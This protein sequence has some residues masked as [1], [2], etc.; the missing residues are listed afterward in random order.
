V[1]QA[2]PVA[3]RRSPAA[4]GT[5]GLWTFLFID[6]VIFL[7]MFVAYMGERIRQTDLY[8]ASQLRLDEFVGLVNTLI[9]VTSSWMVVEAIRGARREDGEHVRRFLGLAWLLGLAFS[10]VKLGEYRLKIKAGWTP[11]TNSFFSFYF[12]ITSVHLL[13][14]LAGMVFIAHCRGGARAR[15]GTS[16]Y[17]SLLENTGLF[18][19]LVDVLWLFI[20]PLLYLVGRLQ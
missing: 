15:V 1:S 6:M 3:A 4:P 14:V 16:R 19:H 18:W 13:H 7:M 17:L 5:D 20:F 12:F 8:A 11:A 2:P 9:L 10:I